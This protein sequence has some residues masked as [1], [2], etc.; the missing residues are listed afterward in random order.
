MWDVSEQDN[1][2]QIAIGSFVELTEGKKI[3]L[4][5]DTANGGRLIVV[6]L[7]HN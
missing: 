2:K 5:K 1:H 4:D 7:V 6:Q 3:L